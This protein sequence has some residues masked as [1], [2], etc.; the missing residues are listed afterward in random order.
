[1]VSE[2]GRLDVARREGAAPFTDA[3]A[4]ATARVGGAIAIGI[5]TSLRFDAARVH[6]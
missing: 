5:R 3:D 2:P 6:L 4:A 1:M